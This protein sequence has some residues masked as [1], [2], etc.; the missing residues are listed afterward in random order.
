[1]G[2]YEDLGVKP[3][4]NAAGPLTRLSGSRLHPDVSA[5][6]VEASQEHVRIEELQARA[7]EIIAEVT[8]AEAGYVVPGAA[9]GLTLAAAACLARLDLVAMDRLPETDGRPNEII[10]QRAHRNA[11]DHALRLSG[12]RI[13][14]VGYLGFPGA[15][16]TYPWQIEAAITERTVAIAHPV[17][18]AP[19]TVPLEAVVAIAHRHNLP[20][21]VDAAAALPPVENLWRFI[22]AGADLVTFSGGKA[23][24]APQASGILCG[25]RDLIESV[26][27]QHQDM[28]V[29]PETWGLRDHYLTSGRLAGPPHHGIGRSMK[30]GK[31]EIVGLIVALRRFLAHDHAADV[32]RWNAWLEAL[33]NSLAERAG[34]QVVVRPAS[35][36]GRPYPVLLLWL[37]ETLA[38]L[39][40][41]DLVNRL[42]ES[43]PPICVSQSHLHQGAL[44]IVPTQLAE[45]QVGIVLARLHSLLD[46]P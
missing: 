5:A 41:L 36:D 16:C 33:A 8:G 15:G 24:G 3:V 9:A 18:A 40:C 43:D 22:A 6:M 34:V 4:I 10:A 12:A 7:G 23:I 11:Y 29:L 46:R 26:A 30:V 25:R 31:E 38:G 2:I 39:T 1:M 21:I 45:T 19:G 17:M 42:A 35:S 13:I 28:D 44:T 37:D 27:L 20:V 14:D 32:A